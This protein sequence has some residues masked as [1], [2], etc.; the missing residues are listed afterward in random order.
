MRK[1]GKRGRGWGRCE[2]GGKER[3]RWGRCEEGGTDL[4]AVG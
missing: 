4:M 2:E 1:E 3:E